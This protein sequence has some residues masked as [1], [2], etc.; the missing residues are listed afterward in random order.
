MKQFLFAFALCA[1]AVP[2][3]AGETGC[4]YDAQG[5]VELLAPGA[6]DWRA[7]RK[8]QPVTEGQ[9]LRTAD[10]AWCEVLFKDGT[11]I[12]LE[13]ASELS[14]EALKA[15]KEER[16]FAFAFLRGKALWM[17]AK[18][19]GALPSRFS[20]RTPSSVC[21]VRGTDFSIIVS[22]GSGSS[23]IGL[24]EGKMAVSGAG[25]EK[26][27][28]A[29]GEAWADSGRVT[30][31]SRL[32]KLMK[33][34]QRRYLRLKARVDGLRGRLAERDAFIDEYI[35]RQERKLSDFDARREEKLKKH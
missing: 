5:R 31:E 11:F 33:A 21:A 1:C 23:V 30:V 13:A 29:G 22:S 9:T 10:K 32:S 12:K 4:I 24:F 6:K 14:L 19:K 25:G 20:V 3:L 17:A 18:L 34:E 35:G 7:A 15:T 26:E 16:L 8:G 28:P 27:L 2:L